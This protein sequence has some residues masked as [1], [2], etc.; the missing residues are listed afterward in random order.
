MGRNH[1]AI[2]GY[3]G[4][5]YRVRIRTTRCVRPFRGLTAGMT[6]WFDASLSSSSNATSITGITCSAQEF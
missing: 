6:Y 4:V 5:Y 2:D 3:R 1:A